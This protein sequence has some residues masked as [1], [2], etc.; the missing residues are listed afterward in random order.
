MASGFSGDAV[1]Q[2][3]RLFRDGTASGL[4]DGQLIER[5]TTR[6]AEAA[7]IAFETLVNRHGPMVLRVIRGLLR[8]PRDV[9]DAF[10]AT[11]LVLVKKAHA[12]GERDLLGPWL[13]GVAR[14]VALK[15]RKVAAKRNQREG[16][17]ID[18]PPGEPT[19]SPW[20]D[21]RP[22]LHEELSRLPD[23][24]KKPV[25]LCHLQGLTHA[26]AA[27]ELAWPVGTVS[28]RLTRARK[29]L[30]DRLTRRGLSTTANL[31]PIGLLAE[32]ASA[33]VPQTW[34]QTTTKAAIALA[35]GKKLAA[36]TI[37]AGAITLTKRT[38]TMML[39][40]RLKWLAIPLSLAI[41]AAGGMVVNQ[42]I[43]I[44]S[45]DPK[46]KTDLAKAEAAKP[47]NNEDPPPANPAPPLQESPF[48]TPGEPMQTPDAMPD[49]QPPPGYFDLPAPNKN[50]GTDP[51]IIKPGQV[52]QI[53]VLEALPGRPISGD[54]VV[55]P[56]G[57][58]S[59]G[60]YG[61]LR[62][63]GLNR[64]QAKVKLIEHLREYITDEVLGLVTLDFN[65][66]SL[67]IPPI[68]SNR[69]MVDD[70]PNYF[71][72]GPDQAPR[73]RVTTFNRD[74][75]ASNARINQLEEK[76]DRVLKELE[77]LRGVSRPAQ[78]EPAPPTRPAE[79][80]PE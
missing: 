67:P 30:K 50:D 9:E 13:Y 35:I 61:D 73:P 54:R 22:I 21:L 28:V 80:P 52:L 65:N 40:N 45:A 57:T 27:Q 5:F 17:L 53:E 23:K 70:S 6:K 15:A 41:G 49:F 72:G 64:D 62:V 3:N 24:Y 37:S 42:Q 12:I 68:K 34:I 1:R 47:L 2:I 16:G 14:R 7:E 10:Q 51:P 36:G 8:D 60:F 26:E 20:L 55:R 46:A 33:I 56:D 66:K 79:K 25:I 74:D 39:V 48:G 77:A 58:I 11:F 63:A 69:V 43:Q 38:L 59:L 71:P 75:P 29:L 44:R 78:P 18:D 4:T 76:L 31:W 32:G 19:E